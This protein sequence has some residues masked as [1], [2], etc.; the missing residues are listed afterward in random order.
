MP[1]NA[2]CDLRQKAIFLVLMAELTNSFK[3]TLKVNNYWHGSYECVANMANSGTSVSRRFFLL[4]TVL[5]RQCGGEII[6]GMP[7]GFTFPTGI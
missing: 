7:I 6:M 1:L 3:I 2:N 5:W 4:V